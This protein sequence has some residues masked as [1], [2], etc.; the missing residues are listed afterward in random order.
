MLEAHLAVF[1]AVKPGVLC[2][3]VDKVARDIIEKDYPGTFGHGLGHGVGFDI[4]EWPRFS[5][6]D[7]TP[8]AEGMVITNERAST[9][10][11]SSACASRT[12]SWSPPTAG[13]SLTK[14]P[15]E[16]IEL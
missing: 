3:D 16:L 13:R 6:L 12:C 7:K 2:C 14:S 15:K 8:C 4:H 10:P 11:P 5:K 1:D 9:C